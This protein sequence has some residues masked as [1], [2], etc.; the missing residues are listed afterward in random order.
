MKI[1]VEAFGGDNARLEVI[2]GCRDAINNLGVEITLTGDK[3]KIEN[4]AKENGIDILTGFPKNFIK[5]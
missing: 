3:A 1:I 4:T 5:V 2:K